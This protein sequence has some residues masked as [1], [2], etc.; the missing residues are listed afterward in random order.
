MSSTD[1]FERVRKGE[2]T[3][4]QGAALLE[5]ARVRTFRPGKPAWMPRLVYVCGLVVLALVIP[6]LLSSRKA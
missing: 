4:A 3:P 1:V 2:I 5:Q 6:N